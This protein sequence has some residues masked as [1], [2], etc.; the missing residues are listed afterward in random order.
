[1]R[2]VHLTLPPRGVCA[3]M[4]PG[5]A[6]K[7]TL[8]RTVCGLYEGAPELDVFGTCLYDGAPA[9]AGHRPALVDQRL[10]ISMSTAAEVLA[11]NL[12]QRHTLTRAQQSEHF[13]QLAHELDASSLTACFELPCVEL[14]LADRRRLI[15]LRAALASPK[16]LCVDEPTAGLSDE[17]SAGILAML[18]R[19]AQ[20]ACVLFVTHHLAQARQHAAQITLLASGRVIETSAPEAFFTSSPNEATRDYARTGYCCVPSLEADTEV[21][22]DLDAETAPSDPGE[23]IWQRHIEATAPH[24]VPSLDRV[25]TARVGAPAEAVGPRGFRW[26]VQGRLAGTPQPGLLHKLEQDVEAL[27]RVGV[28]VLVSLIEQPLSLTEFYCIPAPIPDMKAPS[29]DEAARLCAEVSVLVAQGE[30]VAFHCKAGLGR[31]GTMLAAQ[32]IWG[33]LSAEEALALVRKVNPQW[34][35]SAEQEDFLAAFG[36]WCAGPELD[37]STPRT[38]TTG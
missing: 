10:S 23:L 3:L 26:L 36:A 35:Q 12:P 6:G 4:G 16:L 20:R 21:G 19:Y 8:V 25:P 9:R 34:V 7:S 15:I 22:D 27:R 17:D 28:T 2:D 30:V 24:R 32:L 37:P 14:S 13:A 38:P 33:G 29:I 18:D 5:G 11:T 1:L 31:T